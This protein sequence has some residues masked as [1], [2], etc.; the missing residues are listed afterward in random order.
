[1][2]YY[3]YILRCADNSLY[4]GVTQSLERRVQEHNSQPA[5]GAKY[6]RAKLPVTL[7]YSEVEKDL[8]A[9]LKREAQIK[10]LTK[11]KKEQLVEAYIAK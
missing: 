8:G 4:C 5:K 9:A 6:T 7:I 3:V 11:T 10:K 2:K 1:M